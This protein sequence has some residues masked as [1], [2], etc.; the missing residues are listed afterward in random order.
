MG[1]LKPIWM[2][3]NLKKRDK[4]IAAV[5]RLEDAIQLENAAINAPMEAVAQA[6]CSRIEAAR[7]NTSWTRE[8][9]LE[10]WEL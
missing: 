2:T 7:V 4:A 5:Q 3:E 8:H 1:L 9:R 6:A 10:M